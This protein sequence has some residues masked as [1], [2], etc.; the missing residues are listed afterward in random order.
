MNT[1]INPLIGANIRETAENA[2]EALRGA[3]VLMADRHSD[4]TRLLM[5]VL[6]RL[7]RDSEDRENIETAAES[8][9]AV[10]TLMADRYSDLCRLLMPV[11]N[12]LEHAAYSTDKQPQKMVAL[13]PV[14]DYNR[15][16]ALVRA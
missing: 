9:S 1:N 12:A 8:F 5:P 11:L 4:L 10:I 6:E 16:A 3:L 13:N 7:E 15:R 14:E 2:E